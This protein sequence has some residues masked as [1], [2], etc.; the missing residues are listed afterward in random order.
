MQTGGRTEF[1]DA[2]AA[3]H[4]LT[5]AHRQTRDCLHQKTHDVLAV[6]YRE[7][8]IPGRRVPGTIR[9]V[10]FLCSEVDAAWDC[11]KQLTL[12]EESAA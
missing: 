3:E 6:S 2:H 7:G 8:R 11:E 4:I 10:R 5:L 9:P 1:C 12:T